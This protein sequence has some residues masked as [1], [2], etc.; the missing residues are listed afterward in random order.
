MGE[1]RKS[2]E[3]FI[4]P[5]TLKIRSTTAT[6][7]KLWGGNNRSPHP[8]QNLFLNVGIKRYKAMDKKLIYY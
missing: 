6:T 1:G 3:V 7:E 8:F 2:K 4:P 5:P